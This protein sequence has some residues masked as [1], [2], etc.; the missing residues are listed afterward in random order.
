M[1]AERSR[2][3]TRP[4]R[5][6][7]LACLSA[8]AF[9]TAGAAFAHQVPSITLEADFA[10]NRSFT[11][12]INLDPRL[13]LSDE[14]TTLAPVPG[15]W[16]LERS[17]A[18][19]AKI[20]EDCT[21]YLKKNV[22][23][24]FG[25]EITPLPSLQVIPIDGAENTPLTPETPELHLLATGRG[26]LP[27]SAKDFALRL[28]RESNS[29]VILLNKVEGREEPSLRVVFPGETSQTFELAGVRTLDEMLGQSAAPAPAA[30]DAVLPWIIRGVVALLLLVT[31]LIFRNQWRAPLLRRHR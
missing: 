11:L 27:G 21:A 4:R 14:P 24:V 8:F 29:S 25:A 22:E 9:C 20:H 1:P 17:P 7:R 30:S 15:A 18:E 28:G 5:W 12:R 6:T 10:R 26:I 2:T 13:V 31:W 23:L 19:V 3:H 16:Y